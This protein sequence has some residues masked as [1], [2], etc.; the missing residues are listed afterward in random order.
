MGNAKWKGVRLRDVLQK[1]ELAAEAKQVI[2]N[3]LDAP[4]APNVPD[5]VKAID[6]EQALDPDIILAFEMNGEPLPW[7][8]GYPLR[9]VVPGHYG[10]YWVKHLNEITVVD[11]QFKGFWMDPAYRIPTRNAPRSS[12][13]RHRSTPCRSID[14]MFVRSLPAWQMAPPQR[15][16][17]RCRCGASPSMADTAFEKCSS[18]KTTVKIGERQRLGMTSANTPSASGP[19]RL[20]RRRLVNTSCA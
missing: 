19:S 16:A 14:S 10:T 1:A 18:A 15:R 9:L 4:P 3:G 13:G 2:F 7:M 11:D 12:R 6:V 5:F 17:G 8:N 20:P